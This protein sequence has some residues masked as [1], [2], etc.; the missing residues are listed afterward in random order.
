MRNRI[1]AIVVLSLLFCCFLISCDAEMKT[2]PAKPDEGKVEETIDEKAL[3][4]PTII[5]DEAKAGLAGILVDVPS[6]ID[7]YQ[8]RAIPLF[9]EKDP[10]TD[11]WTGKDNDGLPIFG[12]Q[13]TWRKFNVSDD[14]RFATLGWYRQG[15]WRIEL[16]A[17]NKNGQVLMT[18]STEETGD[19]YLQKGKDNIIRVTLH[20][21]D[22]DGREGENQSTGKIIFAFETNWLSN[23]IETQYIRI[24]VDKFT[25]DGK[26]DTH[27]GRHNTMFPLKNGTQGSRVWGDGALQYYDTSGDTWTRPDGNTE[28]ATYGYSDAWRTVLKGAQ[29][30]IFAS[31]V[32]DGTPHN[33]RKTLEAAGFTETVPMG[34]IRF[35]AETSDLTW[36]ETDGTDD[37]GTPVKVKIASGGIP[38]GNYLV[39]AKV[40][41]IDKGTDKEIVI[42]GQSMA[43]KVVGGE[44]TTVTG[45]LLQEKYIKTGLSVTIPENVNGSLVLENGTTEFVIKADV[46]EGTSLTLKYAP[47]N[48]TLKETDLAYEWR[49]NGEKV[50]GETGSTFTFKPVKWGDA[51]ITCIVF[52]KAG[53]TGF[54]G[55]LNSETMVVRVCEAS[56]PNQ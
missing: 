1:T 48:D 55:E 3:V 54:M 43:V 42:G 45:S 46:L 16:R 11:K 15:Y 37:D 31:Y 35:Y 25:T 28:T 27:S 5:I 19:V 21:D 8:Y 23:D 56:G 36:S 30:L 29:D 20:T 47:D 22:G 14:G 44:V 33:T 53:D 39:R 4:E 6:E 41:T 12:S 26:I 18:G 32:N 17:L 13:F 9:G 52:G 10:Q 38:A 49:L 7:K 2:N 34:R 50:S 51:K 24:E 40:C